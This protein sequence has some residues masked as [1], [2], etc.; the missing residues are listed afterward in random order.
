[1]NMSQRVDF[2][3]MTDRELRAYRRLLR[4]RRTMR[5]K[6]CKALFMVALV[7][8][9]VFCVQSV[10]SKVYAAENQ[11]SSYKYY[12]QI[13]V[14]SGDTLWSI[15][16]DYIDY[17]HYDGIKDYIKEVCSINHCNADQLRS[18]QTLVVPYYSS[19]YV[20]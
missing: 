12:T 13:T 7:I 18:G 15:A 2:S 14:E 20:Y 1:M 8:F 9:C 16:E 11:A 4:R 19:E 17:A 6:I 5:I 3:S 10:S